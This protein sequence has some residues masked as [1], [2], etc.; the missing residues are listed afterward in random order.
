VERRDRTPNPETVRRYM[1]EGE[2]K[3]GNVSERELLIIR[4]EGASVRCLSEN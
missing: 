3:K 4:S 1:A 2:R